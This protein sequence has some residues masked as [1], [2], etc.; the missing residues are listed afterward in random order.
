MRT[1]RKIRSKKARLLAL[2]ENGS[3]P[4][5]VAAR[6]VYPGDSEELANIKTVQL[7]GA[8]RRVDP[9]FRFSVQN[10]QIVGF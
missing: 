7:L 1:I 4:L 5:N 9:D 8:Y 3:V 6:T 2:L 10:R